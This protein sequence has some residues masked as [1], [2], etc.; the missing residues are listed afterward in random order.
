[1]RFPARCRPVGDRFLRFACKDLRE[2]TLTC[3]PASPVTT[4]LPL[5]QDVMF[6]PG[7]GRKQIADDPA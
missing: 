5:A 1:M 2:V 4:P 7:E 6:V 3:G